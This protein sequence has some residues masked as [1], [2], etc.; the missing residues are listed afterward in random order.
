MLQSGGSDR[1]DGRS[2][3][4]WPPYLVQSETIR[5]LRCN[6]AKDVLPAHVLRGFTLRRL[7]RLPVESMRL[8]QSMVY[9]QCSRRLS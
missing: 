1:C 8:T 2:D 3:D 4:R 6:D 9:R 5:S 7:A